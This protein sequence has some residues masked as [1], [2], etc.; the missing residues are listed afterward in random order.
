MHYFPSYRENKS[1]VEDIKRAKGSLRV[2]S[3]FSFFSKTLLCHCY[4][5]P[6]ELGGE[7]G[8]STLRALRGAVDRSDKSPRQSQALEEPERFVERAATFKRSVQS[9]MGALSSAVTSAEEGQLLQ[10]MGEEYFL[11]KGAKSELKVRAAE[12]QAV[13]A[14][15][16]SHPFC[17]CNG[18]NFRVTFLPLFSSAPGQVSALALT[19]LPSF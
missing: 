17:N 11:F 6:A 10:Q 12:A 7:L 1:R 8:R 2:H 15:A 3:H 14:S 5:L 19:W 16:G 18:L 13:P 4:S 9:F